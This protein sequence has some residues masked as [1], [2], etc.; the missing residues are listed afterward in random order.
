MTKRGFYNA[1]SFT[2]GGFTAPLHLPAEPLL[3]KERSWGSASISFQCIHIRK[4]IH[5]HWWGPLQLCRHLLIITL[6][7]ISFR[8]PGRRHRTTR[9]NLIVRKMNGHFPPPWFSCLFLHMSSAI[10]T[11]CFLIFEADDIKA[12]EHLCS[13]GLASP[14][15]VCNGHTSTW[16]YGVH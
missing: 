10:L 4:L 2:I 3:G 5:S 8:R 15:A 12:Y 11:F 7:L 13:G 14:R 1:A 6:S 9:S 16:C